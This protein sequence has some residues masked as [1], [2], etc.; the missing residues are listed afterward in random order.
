MSDLEVLQICLMQ[1]KVL[2]V[3]IGAHDSSYSNLITFD[4]DKKK[5]FLPHHT[6]I[7][8]QVND[9]E[10]VIWR[11][12]VDEGTFICMMLIRCWKGLASPALIPSPTTLKDFDGNTFWPHGIIPSFYVYVGEKL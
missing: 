9:N 10:L 4:I 8:I 3:A 12:V 5:P 1:C 7:Q 11:M 2:L 6:P